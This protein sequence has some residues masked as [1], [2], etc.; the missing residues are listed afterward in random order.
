M[1]YSIVEFRMFSF[2]FPYIR[3]KGPSGVVTIAFTVT[4]INL[5]V[6]ILNHWAFNGNV[7]D[8]SMV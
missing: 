8:R 6:Q 1:N 4:G 2:H 7:A 5:S 3:V